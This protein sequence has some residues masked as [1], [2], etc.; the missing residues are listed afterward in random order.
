[1][2]VETYV[3]AEHHMTIT[4]KHARLVKDTPL[5]RRIDSETKAAV[6]STNLHQRLSPVRSSRD[7]SV[8]SGRIWPLTM[9]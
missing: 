6:M 3:R 9:R 4:I 8:A 1:M 2:A 5:E 7:E